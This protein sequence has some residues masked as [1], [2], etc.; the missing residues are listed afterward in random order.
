MKESAPI[1]RPPLPAP[2]RA[3]ACRWSGRHPGRPNFFLPWRISWRSWRL[4]GSLRSCLSLGE[5]CNPLPWQT[6]CRAATLKLFHCIVV[7]GAA[8]GSGCG[9][10]EE[11]PAPGTTDARSDDPSTPATTDA[12]CP[13]EASP[14]QSPFGCYSTDPCGS[15]QYP[16]SPKDCP[17][18][19]Q[20]ECNDPAGCRCDLTAPLSPADCPIAAQFNCAVWGTPSCGCQCYADAALDPTACG[21]DGGASGDASAVCPYGLWECRSYDPPVGCECRIAIA[22]L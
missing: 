19:Q 1:V 21:C 6:E 18:P 20:L 3:T 8:M 5:A 17:S 2:R 4:G 14:F 13:A 7:M 9:G 10:N 12:D 16:R 11:A 22:I 15:M